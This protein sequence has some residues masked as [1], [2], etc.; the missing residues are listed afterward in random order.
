M[1]QQNLFGESVVVAPAAKKER[2]VDVDRFK[3]PSYTIRLVREGVHRYDDDTVRSSDQVFRLLHE[4]YCSLPHEEFG[5]LYLTGRSKIITIKRDL[6][7]GSLHSA[8]VSP[9]EILATGLLL[10]AAAVVVFHNHPS[11]DPAPS[12]E[13]RLIT[14]KSR[15]Q[16]AIWILCSPIM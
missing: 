11:G 8:V 10:N 6:F 12:A 13:D 14:K 15:L 5:A 1:D 9:R 3:I 16:G 4:Y 7:R 2:S